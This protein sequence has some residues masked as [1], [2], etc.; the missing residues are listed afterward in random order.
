MNGVFY[1]TLQ[2]KNGQERKLLQWFPTLAAR[3]ELYERWHQRGIVVTSETK[4]LP[5]EKKLK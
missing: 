3:S 4:V 2:A 1:I 5:L